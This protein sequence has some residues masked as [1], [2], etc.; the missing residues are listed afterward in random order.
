M[1]IDDDRDHNLGTRNIRHGPEWASTTFA[2]DVL[3]RVALVLSVYFPVGIGRLSHNRIATA[4]G[5]ASEP[6]PTAA[7][8]DVCRHPRLRIPRR[9]HGCY[10]CRNVHGWQK[11]SEDETI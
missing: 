8:T 9:A 2:K 6:L 10:I 1:R 3:F 4:A 11:G 5:T 7:P